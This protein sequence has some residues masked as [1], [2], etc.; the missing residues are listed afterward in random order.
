M[1]DEQGR[2]KTFKFNYRDVSRGRSV[3]QNILLQPGDTVVVR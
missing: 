1:R 2:T 3:E